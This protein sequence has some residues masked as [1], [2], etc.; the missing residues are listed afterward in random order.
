MG[1]FYEDLDTLNQLV[2]KLEK[3]NHI[4]E[5]IIRAIRYATENPTLSVH[6]IIKDVKNKTI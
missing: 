3:K 5:F 6:Q 1:K 4:S 2:K